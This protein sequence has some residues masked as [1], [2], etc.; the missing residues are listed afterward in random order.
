MAQR[1]DKRRRV[2]LTLENGISYKALRRVI[3]RLA[4]EPRGTE[5]VLAPAA[6]ERA[7]EEEYGCLRQVISLDRSSGAPFE[8]EVGLAHR[9]IPR[10]LQSA[11]FAPYVLQALDHFGN[12]HDRPWHLILYCDELVPGAARKINNSRKTWAYYLSVLEL[13]RA[14]LSHRE[15]WIP[16]GFLRSP[17]GRDVVGGWSTIAAKLMGTLFLGPL[18]IRDAGVVL[19]IPGCGPR[20]VFFDMHVTIGGSPALEQLWGTMGCNGVVP[21][22]LGCLN[23][24]SSSSALATHDPSHSLVDTSCADRSKFIMASNRQIWGEIDE[25]RAQRHVVTRTRFRQMEGIRA[26]L[27]CHWASRET[28]T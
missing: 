10:Y 4:S 18:S 2:L 17:I 7:L 27:R 22:S 19:D 25:L 14:L 23:V 28:G 20:V 24:V 8:W 9:V 15:A 3:E 26:P 21:C 1:H 13:P 6:V 12:S 5:D 16:I 11:A